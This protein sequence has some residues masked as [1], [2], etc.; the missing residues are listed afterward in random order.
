MGTMNALSS[1]S[2][3]DGTKRSLS[4]VYSDILLCSLTAIHPSFKYSTAKH[5]KRLYFT[6]T[7]KKK[8]LCLIFNDNLF[9]FYYRLIFKMT[10]TTSIFCFIS[11]S[12]SELLQQAK[13][14]T[15]AAKQVVEQKMDNLN[16]VYTEALN[17]LKALSSQLTHLPAS[18][19]MQKV[20]QVVGQYLDSSMIHVQYNARNIYPN[21][22][23]IFVLISSIN[24]KKYTSILKFSFVYVLLKENDIIIIY[25]YTPVYGS[26]F[27]HCLKSINRGEITQLPTTVSPTNYKPSLCLSLLKSSE[28]LLLFTLALN[29]TASPTPWDKLDRVSPASSSPMYRLFN[30]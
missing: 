3:T 12:N 4:Y 2:T 25:M 21:I 24:G 23:L 18:E 16:G 20:D 14:L 10:T 8:Q 11:P 19:L 28:R 26:V 5:L 27:L 17:Q 13:P 29:E 7:V 1:S 22:V 30:R 6:I 9:V 15:D